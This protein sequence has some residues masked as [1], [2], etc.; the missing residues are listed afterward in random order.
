M[1]HHAAHGARA[2]G[3]PEPWTGLMA[4]WALPRRVLVLFGG[5]A[6]AVEGAGGGADVH[7]EGDADVGVP[8]Q[9]G[10]VGG[11]HLPGEQGG[12][13][14]HVPQAV[15]DPGAVAVGVAPSGGEVGG[16]QAAAGGGGGP[17]GRPA[18]GG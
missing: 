1:A 5:G 13:A 10:D 4:A 16:G 14:E 15:P 17:A 8:G 9:T 6:G 2:E 18:S 7:V 11:V 3:S 12:G